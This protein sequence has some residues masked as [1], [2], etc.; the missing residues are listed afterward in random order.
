MRIKLFVILFLLALTSVSA[1]ASE[2]VDSGQV[3]D[4]EIDDD[5]VIHRVQEVDRAIRWL[6]RKYPYWSLS[7]QHDKRDEL[8]WDIVQVA[9]EYELPPEIITVISYRESS[10]QADAVGQAGEVG[11]MQTLNRANKGCDLSTPIGQLR[12]GAGWLK[13]A[14]AMCGSWRGA[15]TAYAC[16]ACSSSN[17][18]TQWI[19]ESRIRQWEKINEA[20]ERCRGSDRDTYWLCQPR[21]RKL[22]ASKAVASAG[23]RERHADGVGH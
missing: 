12:C 23:P 9:M 20:N 15:L 2:P 5:S 16:G 19:V 10:F 21:G 1:M 6:L 7:V 3:I 13:K 18:K 8:A 4:P 14:M 11:L 17:P 22:P